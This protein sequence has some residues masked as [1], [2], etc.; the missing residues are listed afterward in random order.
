[1]S[2]CAAILPL[3]IYKSELQTRGYC[4]QKQNIQHGRIHT[5]APPLLLVW[6]TSVISLPTF[7]FS[8]AEHVVKR[9]YMSESQ[10]SKLKRGGDALWEKQSSDGMVPSYSGDTS[11]KWLILGLSSSMK[12]SSQTAETLSGSW[13]IIDWAGGAVRRRKKP[14][15]VSGSRSLKSHSG[16]L[17]LGFNSQHKHWQRVFMTTTRVRG[18]SNLYSHV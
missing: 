14:S 17:G 18:V 10:Y 13:G 15:Q 7:H 3:W 6:E 2:N 12:H 9:K 11:Q 1:M 5:Q 8:K 4:F 16:Q